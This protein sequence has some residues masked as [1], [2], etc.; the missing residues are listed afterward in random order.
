[1]AETLWIAIDEHL[2]GKLDD[3][4][5]YTETYP[6]QTVIATSIQS[7]RDWE[8]WQLP[9]LA[10]VGVRLRRSPGGHD[11]GGVLGSAIPLRLHYDKEMTYRVVAIG[12]GKQAEATQFAKT[13]EKRIEAALRALTWQGV[14]ADD[15]EVIR[16]WSV[17]GSDI[18][19]LPK[20]QSD[21]VWYGLA[22]V[23]LTIRTHI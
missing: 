2:C 19:V 15:G 5:R 14:T 23:G 13:M 8:Q 6:A 18:T 12:A 17:D 7:I 16:S 21:Q 11:G 10:I 4:L 3:A 1:M 20:P 9:A 22:V